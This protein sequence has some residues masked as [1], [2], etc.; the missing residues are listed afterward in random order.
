MLKALS[1]PWSAARGFAVGLA[2]AVAVPAPHAQI[3]VPADFAVLQ[4]AI[5]AANPNDVIVI[6]TGE[7]A[8]ITITKSLTL[9]GRGDRPVILAATPLQAGGHTQIPTITLAGPGR[10]VVTL[11]NL[12]TGGVTDGFFF[13]T[14]TTVIQADGF[15]ELRILHCDIEA[16]KWEFLSGFAKDGMVGITT[17]V[18]WLLVEDSMVVGGHG[19]DDISGALSFFIPCGNSGIEST[20]TVTLVDSVVRGGDGLDTVLADDFPGG[21]PNSCDDISGGTGGAGVSAT[22]LQLAGSVV[23][24]GHGARV[25]CYDT[26]SGTTSTVCDAA[27]GVSIVAGTAVEHLPGTLLGS[28]PLTLGDEWSLTWSFT[29]ASGLLLVSLLPMPGVQVG[30]KGKL[31]MNTS[32]II[33]ISLPG[34]GLNS[35]SF[36]IPSAPSLTGLSVV[37]QSYESPAGLSRPLFG[38]LLE[39]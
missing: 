35:G 34:N 8:P 32:P 14:T 16:P 9:V 27:D 18:P 4:D 30:A 25:S 10:G 38:T 23:Q 13:G 12:A 22:L 6:D 2:V 15:D 37:L 11:S 29:S 17:S 28:G 21:C 36:A 24:G 1:G 33:T 7:Y 26:G 20:G 19:D 5:D 39:G 3:E 31:F